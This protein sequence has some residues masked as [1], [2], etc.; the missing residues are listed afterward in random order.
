LGSV[1]ELY[2]GECMTSVD[3]AYKVAFELCSL[4][5]ERRVNW[6]AV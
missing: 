5:F 1:V 3:R 4:L 6:S 2:A